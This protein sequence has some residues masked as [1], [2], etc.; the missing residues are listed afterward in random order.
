MSFIRINAYKLTNEKIKSLLPKENDLYGLSVTDK[1]SNPTRIYFSA[2]NWHNGGGGYTKLSDYRIY[3]VNHEFGHA[4]GHGHSKCPK[5]G[6]PAD[7]MQQ[8]TLGTG[9]CYPYPWVVKP[10]RKNS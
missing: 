2:E 9:Q 10:P 7:I 1:R 3:V 8:Q 4:L 6:G 5:P